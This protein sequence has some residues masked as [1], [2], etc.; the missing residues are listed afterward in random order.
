MI[1]CPTEVPMGCRNWEYMWCFLMLEGWQVSGFCS[2]ISHEKGTVD[3]L[4]LG[5]R[6]SNMV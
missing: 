2:F 3:Y 5:A 6:L 4:L 1:Q